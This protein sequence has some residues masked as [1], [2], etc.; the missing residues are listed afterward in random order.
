MRND[1]LSGTRASSVT[2]SSVQR[3]GLKSKTDVKRAKST[4]L[5]RRP[6][7]SSVLRKLSQSKC[8]AEKE[9]LK[10]KCKTV[11]NIANE[12]VPSTSSG[13]A[14]SS[15]SFPVGQGPSVEYSSN[16]EEGEEESVVEEESA[17]ESIQGDAISSDLDTSETGE[18]L[19][20]QE[21][22]S[23]SAYSASGQRSRIPVPIA[24]SSLTTKHVSWFFSF[25][26]T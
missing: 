9:T 17:L 10:G 15:K 20:V 2:S 8:E 26:A 25:T 1:S 21:E 14:N 23:D 6:K 3:Y 24:S 16:N 12:E 4:P 11:I 13:C 5:L 22:L 19:E 7:C 18:E